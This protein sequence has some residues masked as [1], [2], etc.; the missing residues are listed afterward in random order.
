MQFGRPSVKDVLDRLTT[1]GGAPPPRT[2][3]T[4][5]G[6]NEIYLRVRKILSGHS[7]YTD[8]RVPEPPPLSLNTSLPFVVRYPFALCST[9]HIIIISG[10][11]TLQAS[12]PWR[13][14]RG[15][16]ALEG[17]W[18]LQGPHAVSRGM[19]SPADPQRCTF[20][21][22]PNRHNCPPPKMWCHR[23]HGFNTSCSTRTQRAFMEKPS[24]SRPGVVLGNEPGVL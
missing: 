8:Y 4:K 10:E 15:L 12:R 9:F 18:T 17:E 13:C 3:V 21:A 16:R 22:T 14:F 19:T 24:S 23:R 7:W 1:I 2:K 6:K 11:S 20:R 5:T